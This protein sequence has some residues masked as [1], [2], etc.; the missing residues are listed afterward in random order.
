LNS[1]GTALVYSTYL[2]G[3]SNDFGH[4]IA[5]DSAGDAYVTGQT[6]STNF[7]TTSGAFQTS[8]GASVGAF[9]TKLNA[10]GSALVYSSYLTGNGGAYATSIAVD[11]AGNAY[12]TGTAYA[13][14][15]GFDFPTTPN[16]FQPADPSGVGAFGATDPFVT[17]LNASGSALVYSTYLAGQTGGGN[18][19]GNAI[20]V[21]SA[22]DAYVAGQ[23][24]A[25]DFPTTPGAFEPKN[26]AALPTAWAL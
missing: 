23:T 12:V 15:N 2:G 26:R 11:G 20:A 5:V 24:T 7:P 25:V 9:I 4:G 22:G 19:R 3:S 17:R 21:D 13:G 14:V 18:D 10:T 8:L 6:Q 16:A 1:S